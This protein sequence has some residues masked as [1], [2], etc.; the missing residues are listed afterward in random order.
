MKS[1]RG[2][3]LIELLVV[4]AIIGSLVALLL[5]AVNAARAAARRTQCISGMRQ[6]GLALLNYTDLHRGR[7]P[8]VAGH[9]DEDEDHEE[10]E[11]DEEHSW[12]FTLAPFLENV[13]S[14]RM[15]PDDPLWTER[16]ETNGTSYV[17][18]GYLSVVVDD[19]GNTVG[20]N[21]Y[22]S[23]RN[24]KQVK[25]LSRTISMFEAADNLNITDHVHSYEW[26]T[27]EPSHIFDN[28]AQEVAVERH[29]VGANYLFLDA[30]VETITAEDINA[31]CESQFNFAKPQR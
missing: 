28:V 21:A 26:F 24:I 23:V 2:F 12:I 27:A 6:V 20:D 11:H 4:I 13:D 25:A 5:P 3:T 17:M 7:F 10:E 31:W 22:G 15:C 1:Q 9:H 30:H 29:G 18:N 19:V 8:E 14:V 16:I